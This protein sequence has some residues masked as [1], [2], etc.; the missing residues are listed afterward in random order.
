MIEEKSIKADNEVE[1]FKKCIFMYVFD[2]KENLEY[3]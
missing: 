1:I 3:F 2:Q